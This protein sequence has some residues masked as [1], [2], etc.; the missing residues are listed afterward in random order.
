MFSVAVIGP[1]GAGKT[2]IARRLE[3]AGELPI[4]YL[5]MGINIESSNVALPTSRLI[6]FVKRLR[7]R[8]RGAPAAASHALHHHNGGSR[9]SQSCLWAVLKLCN[10][11]AEE[12]YR[13]YLSWRYRRRGAIVV[14]DR[15]FKFD[16]EREQS[17]TGERRPWTDNLHRWLLA[18]FYPSPDLVI[19]LDAP[20][21]VLHARKQEASLAYL[22]ARRRAFLRQGKMTRN[23]IIVDANQ[24]C[25]TVYAEVVRYIRDF[26]QT[27]RTSNPVAAG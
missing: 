25:D 2:T 12:W 20:A 24:P 27:R 19:Y 26:H 13:Q 4:K 7:R 16:F 3:S 21:E 15:H 9:K 17:H 22:E 10:R 1:D 11:L 23:F 6:E 18:R 8:Q 5:Y 14:Y